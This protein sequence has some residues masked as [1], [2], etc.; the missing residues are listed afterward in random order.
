MKR[1][2]EGSYNTQDTANLAVEAL[3]ARGYS[4]ADMTF[5]ANE[6]AARTLA[7]LPGVRILVVE[8]D[9]DHETGLWARIK[10]AF[11]RKEHAVD[12]IK[13]DELLRQYQ[14]KLD[15]GSI[16]L[17]VESGLDDRDES[18]K[19]KIDDADKGTDL[20]LDDDGRRIVIP[21]VGTTDHTNVNAPGNTGVVPPI[22]PP[23]VDVDGDDDHDLKR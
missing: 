20:N 14:D 13:D 6:T 1:F 23:V 11:G 22:V 8:T 5:I 12:L 10:E 9:H 19:D 3:V 4:K 21:P 2:V 17:L 15:Q 16:L 18:L 7:D